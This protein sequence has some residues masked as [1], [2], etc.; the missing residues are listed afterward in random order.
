VKE[1]ELL[2]N[3][4]QLLDKGDFETDETLER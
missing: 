1:E 2:S 4:Q 3:N